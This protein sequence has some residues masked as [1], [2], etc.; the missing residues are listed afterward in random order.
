MAQSQHRAARP[1]RGSDCAVSRAA[2]DGWER[3]RAPR[4]EGE[5]HGEVEP[6]AEAQSLKCLATIVHPGGD[7]GSRAR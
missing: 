6:T 7:S 2:A 1:T 4:P 3:Y 5:D